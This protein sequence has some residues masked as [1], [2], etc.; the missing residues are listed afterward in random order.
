VYDTL[1]H[2]KA[3]HKH[4]TRTGVRQA[5]KPQ[6]AC[7]EPCWPK[8]EKQWGQRWLCASHARSHAQRENQT[9]EG[10]LSESGVLGIL[11]P[12]SAKANSK[13]DETTTQPTRVEL[14]PPTHAANGANLGL[15]HA[16]EA[17]A[18]TKAWKA[19]GI[20]LGVHADRGAHFVRHGLADSPLGLMLA[21]QETNDANEGR[22]STQHRRSSHSTAST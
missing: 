9:R 13:Q 5:E 7:G 18:I 15:K 21:L 3:A 22:C 11:S 17:R 1:K 10:L 19:L 14:A 16:L 8:G 2:N 6:I 4:H 12:G 20:F